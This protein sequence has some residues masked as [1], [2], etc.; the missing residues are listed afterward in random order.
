MEL[1]LRKKGFGL[2]YL[3]SDSAEVAIVCLR[4]IAL[5]A[6]QSLEYSITAILLDR[7]SY[8]PGEKFKARFGHRVMSFKLLDDRWSY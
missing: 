1:V 3:S 6:L 7:L 2:R 8:S 5:V 4:H